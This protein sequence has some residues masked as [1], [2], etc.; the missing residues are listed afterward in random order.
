MSED[1][2]A[3]LQHATTDDEREGLVLQ[4]SLA[5][6]AAEV[7]EAVQVSAVPHWF[8][9]ELLAALMEQPLPAAQTLLRH[10][11]ELSFIEAFPG[12]GHNVHQRTR[13]A[14]L[15]RLWQDDRA[16]F[17]QLS[18]RAAGHCRAQ[19]REVAAWQIEWVYHLLIASPEEGYNRFESAADEWV[20]SYAYDRVE[21]LVGTAEEHAEAGRLSE[22]GV[23]LTR[24]WRA[25][26]HHSYSRFSM[27]RESY[28]DAAQRFHE[29]AEESRE[30]WALY[31][32]GTMAQGIDDYNTARRHYANGLR[33]FEKLKELGGKGL[34][35]T[36]LGSI[37]FALG[38][39]ERAGNCFNEARRIFREIG[40]ARNEANAA[41]WSAEVHRALGDYEVAVAEGREATELAANVGN[42]DEEVNAL[43]GLGRVYCAINE[44]ELAQ[45]CF[46]KAGDKSRQISDRQTDAYLLEGRARVHLGLKDYL[47]ARRCC[48]D[49]VT[50]FR[51]IQDLRGLAVCLRW[52]GQACHG[53]SEVADA[54][55]FYR[56]A[57][58][59][60]QNI[61]DIVGEA[62]SRMHLAELDLGA[63]D[64]SAA[65]A[66]YRFA[67]DRY[68][69]T[70]AKPRTAWAL[71]GCGRVRARVGDADGARCC[72]AE[73]LDLYRAMR[74]P[75]SAQVEAELAAL[76]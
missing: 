8:D 35:T 41:H 68:R 54:S 47:A 14:V 18:S 34:C 74:S 75:H 9:R 55:R 33:I 4:F 62:D 42:L 56:E 22:F 39:F 53:L 19:D 69:A 44:F 21:A 5:A 49:A 23:A 12:R 58:Q 26:V 63:N 50:V 38:D 17:R 10:L 48:E 13:A 3:Q 20:S 73:A 36:G 27:A 52:M 32:A 64:W 51:S 76:D 65:E 45:Q 66:G 30:G 37:T 16:R 7:R 6:L 71:Y 40:D 67:L 11:T 25:R 61:N 15:K 57:L 72:F 2:L 28:E 29:L 46:D 59:T 24:Y 60:C 43:L 70:G 31:G 1:F